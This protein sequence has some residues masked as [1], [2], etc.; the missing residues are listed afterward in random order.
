M[1]KTQNCT[2]I[3][4]VVYWLSS[5]PR[6]WFTCTPCSISTEPR[7]QNADTE[8]VNRSMQIFS[9]N[10]Q[11]SGEV[12]ERD[13][14]WRSWRWLKLV[15]KECWWKNNKECVLLD[16][17]SCSWWVTRELIRQETRIT[18]ASQNSED[19]I[20]YSTSWEAWITATET[21]WQWLRERLE[22]LCWQW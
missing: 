8:T 15:Y 14:G 6:M 18:E 16:G 4:C 3:A 2:N 11:G 13:S 10:T 1:C 21:I 17:G 12:Q 7:T 19:K 22:L 20:T 9:V 5:K